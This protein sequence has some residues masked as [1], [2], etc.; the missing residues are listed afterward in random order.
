MKERWLVAHQRTSGPC[1]VHLWLAGVSATWRCLTE[2][3]GRAN[4][5]EE[6]VVG[7]CLGRVRVKLVVGWGG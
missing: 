7:A 2:C 4:E 3:R 6:Q 5:Y 1:P